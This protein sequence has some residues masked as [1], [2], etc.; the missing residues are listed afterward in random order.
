[1]GNEET[2]EESDMG[3]IANMIAVI[4]TAGTMATD[5]VRTSDDSLADEEKAFQ[6]LFSFSRFDHHDETVATYEAAFEDVGRDK[7]RMTRVLIR[8]AQEAIARFKGIDDHWSSQDLIECNIDRWWRV[9]K[10]SIGSLGEYGTKTAIP[11]LESVLTNDVCGASDRAMDA[12]VKL[13]WDDGRAFDFIRQHFGDGKKIS[14]G[15]GRAIYCTLKQKLADKGLTEETRREYID[16]VMKRA[17]CETNGATGP[18]LDDILVEHVPG[19]RDSEERKA[20][21]SVIEKPDPNFPQFHFKRRKEP[22]GLSYAESRKWHK[23]ED[24]RFHDEARQY[25]EAVKKYKMERNP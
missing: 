17:K 8:L 15:T 23:E 10:C 12:Y 5:A 14:L 11:F 1:M 25:E 22:Q 16:Y 13:A 7:E 18:L 19:Y 20:N 3:T 9:A 2:N 21:L 4:S 6:T 24:K